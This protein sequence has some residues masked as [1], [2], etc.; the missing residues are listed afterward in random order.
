[1]ALSNRMGT[2]T[3]TL[4]KD[5]IKLQSSFANQ[6][7]LHDATGMEFFSYINKLDSML[8]MTQLFYHFQIKAGEFSEQQIYE[9]FFANLGAYNG[10]FVNKLSKLMA[11]LT[12]VEENQL[13]EQ[14]QDDEEKKVEA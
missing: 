6:K 3:F 2:A 1:M 9:C 14:V 5:S 13:L 8:A 7:S 12:G 10:E 4:G 11:D